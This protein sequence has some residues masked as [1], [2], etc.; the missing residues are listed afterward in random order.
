MRALTEG[1][2]PCVLCRPDTEL[3]IL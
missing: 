3:G 2:D 1:V